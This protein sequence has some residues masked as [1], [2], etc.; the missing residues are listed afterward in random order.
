MRCVLEPVGRVRL[1]CGAVQRAW[2]VNKG[3]VQMNRS[4]CSVPLV[5][6]EGIAEGGG[7]NFSKNYLDLT[8][9]KLENR[10]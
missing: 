2:A 3:V 9:L 8:K 1:T 4:V 7:D 10:L 6:G 5:S